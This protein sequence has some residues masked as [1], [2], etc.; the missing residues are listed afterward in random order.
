MKILSEK[1]GVSNIRV[2][3]LFLMIVVMMAALGVSIFALPPQGIEASGLYINITNITDSDGNVATKL[4]QT[5]Y[6]SS[7]T[8]TVTFIANKTITDPDLYYD[9]D[10][11]P[12][13]NVIKLVNQHN[14]FLPC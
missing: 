4:N 8:F 5:E 12:D 3:A 7:T 2:L 6:L 14:Y 11:T 13:G 1:E 9:V 10:A